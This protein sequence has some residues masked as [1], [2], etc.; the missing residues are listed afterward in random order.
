MPVSFLA[1]DNCGCMGDDNDLGRDDSL[2]PVSRLESLE[3]RDGGQ[4]WFLS[5]KC[6]RV[7]A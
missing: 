7:G 2:L 4:S 3:M 1:H 6:D 5:V